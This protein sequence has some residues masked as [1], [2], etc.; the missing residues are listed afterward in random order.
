ME[1]RVVI[2][3]VDVF[4]LVE[5][6]RDLFHVVAHDLVEEDIAFFFVHS[7]VFLSSFIE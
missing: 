3:D 4:V 2:D 7:E 6:L 1:F 5:K